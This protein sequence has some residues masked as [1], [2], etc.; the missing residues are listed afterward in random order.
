MT[1][2]QFVVLKGQCESATDKSKIQLFIETRV[3][4]LRHQVPRKA[5]S[6]VN[7][8][9]KYELG[10]CV[11]LP[12]GDVGTAVLPAVLNHNQSTQLLAYAPE[13]TPK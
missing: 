5:V 8:T 7:N 3:H 11:Q 1:S 10:G 9:L 2:R 6:I 4:D 13:S 12:V